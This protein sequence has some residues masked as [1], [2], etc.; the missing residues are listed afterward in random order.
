MAGLR[1]S[2]NFVRAP[3]GFPELAGYERR[4]KAPDGSLNY[5]KRCGITSSPA[6]SLEHYR[7][8][9]PPFEENR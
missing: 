6:R 3:P 5:A 2:A 9:Q 1:K 7:C 4:R 8:V